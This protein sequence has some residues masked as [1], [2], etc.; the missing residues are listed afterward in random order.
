[1]ESRDSNQLHRFSGSPGSGHVPWGG[2]FDGLRD[3]D[4]DG[5]GGARRMA[6]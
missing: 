2:V 5:C 6:T 3:A 4:Y 1:M